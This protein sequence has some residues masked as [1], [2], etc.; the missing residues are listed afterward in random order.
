MKGA[1]T[2]QTED[3]EAIVVKV[4]ISAVS[5]EGARKNL[6]AESANMEFDAVKKAAFDAWNVALS[7]ISVA[8]GSPEQ[9][10]IFYTSMYHALLNPNLFSD[11]DG[12]YRGMDGEVHSAGESKHYTVF[13]LW[14]TFRATHPLFTITEQEKTN[15]FIQTFIRQYMMVAC[16]RFGNWPETIP[17]V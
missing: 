3:Q 12:Q 5:I 13:S 17:D 10:T 11:V 16:C 8:G 1:M 7:K 14:D 15:E 2:F 4:G 6:E 9:Q